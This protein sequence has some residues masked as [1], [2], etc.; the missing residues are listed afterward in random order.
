MRSIKKKFIATAILLLLAVL[1]IYS[2]LPAVERISID[3]PKVGSG[4]VRIALIAAY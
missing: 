2:W 4:K 3:S 1:A